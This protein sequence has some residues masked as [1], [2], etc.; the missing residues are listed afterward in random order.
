MGYIYFTDWRIKS[1][2]YSVPDISAVDYATVKFNAAELDGYEV[3]DVSL[4]QMSTIKNV[5]FNGSNSADVAV[6]EDLY[7]DNITISG[8]VP[9]IN[10]TLIAYVRGYV[11]TPTVSLE[12]HTAAPVPIPSNIPT[13]YFENPTTLRWTIRPPATITNAFAFFFPG[14]PNGYVVSTAFI[15]QSSNIAVLLF[16]GLESVTIYQSGIWSDYVFIPLNVSDYIYLV[17][18]I[19]GYLPTS[20]ADNADFDDNWLIDPDTDNPIVE[21]VPGG[22]GGYQVSTPPQSSWTG[23]FPLTDDFDSYGNGFPLD[24]DHWDVTNFPRPT[25][26]NGQMEFVSGHNQGSVSCLNNAIL[27][28]DWE[29]QFTVRSVLVSSS[30][31]SLDTYIRYEGGAQEIY[32]RVTCMFNETVVALNGIQVMW[33]DTYNGVYYPYEIDLVT[34]RKK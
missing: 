7:S 26:Q 29:Y 8:F 31:N 30:N 13:I 1:W 20:I 24:A 9:G 18:T 21:T 33:A 3:K 23:E 25:V 34:D 4:I 10:I 5:K 6:G 28:G 27:H 12:F 2:Q 22:E 17:A 16:N 32:V 14:S 19:Q 11:T 15:S